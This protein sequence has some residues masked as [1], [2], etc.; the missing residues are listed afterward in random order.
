MSKLKKVRPI[1]TKYFITAAVLA[2]LAVAGLAG[3][4]LH[5][6]A[7]N[8]GGVWFI[9]SALV[10]A[11]LA[12]SEWYSGHKIKAI[13]MD[14]HYLAAALFDKFLRDGELQGMEGLTASDI[15][16]ITVVAKDGS[17]EQPEEVVAARRSSAGS[18]TSGSLEDL[19][20]ARK[21]SNEA[22]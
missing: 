7:G 6:V 4:I 18:T 21:G 3:G 2:V 20:K 11:Y 13:S 8:A 22:N 12:L 1:S 14:D 16:S 17:G 15:S 19:R 9:V 5:L 10:L